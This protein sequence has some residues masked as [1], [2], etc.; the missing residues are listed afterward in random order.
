[1]TPTERD[2]E[3]VEI[4]ELSREDFLLRHGAEGV[5]VL[6]AHERMLVAASAGDVDAP[7]AWEA[8]RDRMETSEAVVPLRRGTRRRIAALALAATLVLGGTAFAARG[9]FA[10]DEPARGHGAAPL[11]TDDHIGEDDPGVDTGEVDGSLPARGEEA[12]SHYGDEGDTQGGAS[13]ADDSDDEDA[14]EPA[15]EDDDAAVEVDGQADEGVHD[16]E[17]GD[18]DGEDGSDAGEVVEP[19]DS[20][21]GESD[22]EG[23]KDQQRAI[24]VQMTR[25]MR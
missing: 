23:G 16:G 19:E 12:G 22:G 15:G 3:A 25:L 11:L 20:D 2:L 8:F 13:S 9:R 4:G 14:D 6:A 17:D 21:P 5:A 1:M 18:P 10:S 7:A 24:R